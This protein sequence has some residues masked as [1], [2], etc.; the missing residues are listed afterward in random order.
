LFYTNI[1]LLQEKSPILPSVNHHAYRIS[2]FTSLKLLKCIN[3]AFPYVPVRGTL[4]ESNVT[5]S[6][7]RPTRANLTDAK[8]TLEDRAAP[9][10]CTFEIKLF[11]RIIERQKTLFNLIKCQSLRKRLDECIIA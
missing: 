11:W 7:A 9:S 5:I 8:F 1:P 2:F 3:N 6:R 4:N 10:P